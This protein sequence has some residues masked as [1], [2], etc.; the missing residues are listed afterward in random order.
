MKKRLVILATA[1]ALSLSAAFAQD[2]NVKPVPASVVKELHKEFKN[3]SNVQWKITNNFYKASFGFD[4]YLL[5]AF[6]S[7]EGKFIGVS[8]NISV[9]QLPMSLVWE[10]KEKASTFTVA[11][12]FELL[13]TD[14]GTEYFITYKNDKET[15]TYKSS[16]EDWT[17]VN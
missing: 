14:R 17:A 7:Y 13:T 11:N 6:Y 8:R 5:E 4:D 2:I 3:A 12:L 9:E 16:G 1:F 15:K 10:A